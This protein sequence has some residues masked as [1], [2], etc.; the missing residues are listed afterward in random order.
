MSRREEAARVIYR[1]EVGEFPGKGTEKPSPMMVWI[2][3][4]W[5]GHCHH[6][7]PVWME[8]VREFPG[9]QF[10]MINGDDSEFSSD[11]P[12][13]YPR[14]RGYPTIWLMRVGETVPEEY[15]QGRDLKTLRGAVRELIDA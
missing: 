12:E 7:L 14:V 8:L 6:F 5:C 4:E 9:M 1:N 2:Y 3:A 11:Y 15:D 13:T 10:V